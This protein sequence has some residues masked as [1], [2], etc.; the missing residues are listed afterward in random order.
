LVFK[1]LAVLCAQRT[2]VD[3]VL[4][5]QATRIVLQRI[6][7]EAIERAGMM[8]LADDSQVAV[9]G[10]HLLPGRPGAGRYAGVSFRSAAEV[11]MQVSIFR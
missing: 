7:R 8:L 1:T 2:A 3:S 4:P 6:C 10:E 11:A 9:A 5:A